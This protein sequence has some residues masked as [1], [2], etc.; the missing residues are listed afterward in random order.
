MLALFQSR[1]Y[2]EITPPTFEY[3]D[4]FA[5]GAGGASLD[6]AYRFVDRTTGRM[7]LLRPDVTPQVARMAATLLADRPRPLRLCYA[8]PVFRYEEEHLGREREIFQIGAE[9]IGEVSAAADLEILRLVIDLLHA[10]K[11][12]Q[13]KIV[14]GQ[15]EFTR[16][17]LSGIAS[18]PDVFDAI[19]RSVAK[20]ETASLEATL[21]SLKMTQKQ[22]LGVLSLLNLSGEEEVFRWAAPLSHGDASCK[23]LDRLQEVYAAL[24]KSGHSKNTLIDLGEVRGFDYYTGLVFEIFV[25]GIGM[26][27]GGGGRYDHLLERFGT[28]EPAIGFAM[29]IERLQTASAH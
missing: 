17:V 19:L 20:K 10:L 13:F 16:G 25:E 29:D 9:Q 5:R 28:A 1:D 12:T 21:Q 23:G 14:L 4:V 6:H 2:Q 26:A 24:K 18:Q 3:L 8:A 22:R 7:M 11:I 27:V 15:M